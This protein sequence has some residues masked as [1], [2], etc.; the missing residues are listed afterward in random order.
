MNIHLVTFG[1][2]IK[3]GGALTRMLVTASQWTHCNT[4]IFS[5]I[6]VF[7]ET[8]L[9]QSNDF[10]TQH[11][12]FIQENPRGFGYW[13]WKSWLIL[14]VMERIPDNHIV[15][16]LDVG[17]QINTKAIDRFWQYCK[18]ALEQ[19]ICCFHIPGFFEHQWTKADTASRILDTHDHALMHTNQV[20]ATTAFF[21]NN[22]KIRNF[23]RSWYE[24]ACESNYQFLTD[25]IS[26]V[27]N[28]K[29]FK[30]HRHDQSIFS[31]L[32]KKHKICQS[33]PDETY[34]APNWKTAGSS[35]PI[36]ATRNN[37]SI[38]L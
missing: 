32:I 26:V 28:H 5:S 3:Y 38:V 20:I 31:L 29:D 22:H 14:K 2:T 33:L 25:Q 21:L 27:D 23:V 19:D 15:L 10:W 35:S 9:K 18:I 17:C 16:Y 11:G 36:W 12:N 37:T 8:H 24:V 4:K 30:E 13:L 6:N 1:D 7:N 34:F